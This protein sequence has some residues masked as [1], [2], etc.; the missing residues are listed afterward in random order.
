MD[1]FSSLYNQTLQKILGNYSHYLVSVP[2]GKERHH[3]CDEQIR[4]YFH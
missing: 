3:Q 1:T 2:L 4:L